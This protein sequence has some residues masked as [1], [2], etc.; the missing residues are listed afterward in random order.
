[1]QAGINKAAISVRNHIIVKDTA[2]IM[3]H[4]ARL[5]APPRLLFYSATV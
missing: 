4:S 5:H 3:P 1:M 2:F